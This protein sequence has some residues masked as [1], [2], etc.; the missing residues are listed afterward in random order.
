MK[1]YIHMNDGKEY[2]LVSENTSSLAGFCQQ[3]QGNKAIITDSVYINPKYIASIE[4]EQE[5]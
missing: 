4:A 1:L 5:E 3:L 2:I